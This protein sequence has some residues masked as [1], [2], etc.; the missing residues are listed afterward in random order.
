MSTNRCHN[1]NCAARS[2]P[3]HAGTLLSSG[4]FLSTPI[5]CASLL[6]ETGPKLY[7]TARW[8]QLTHP[9]WPEGC[10]CSNVLQ[11]SWILQGFLPTSFDFSSPFDFRK[12]FSMRLKSRYSDTQ[13]RPM[14]VWDVSFGCRYH[15]SSSKYIRFLWSPDARTSLEG[16]YLSL[17]G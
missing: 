12:L 6:V 10:F 9:L 14:W 8:N 4:L 17:C 13:I 15:S 7:L 3:S 16:G 1:A 11:M 5:H 2:P